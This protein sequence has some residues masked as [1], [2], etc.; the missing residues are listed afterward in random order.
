MDWS[1]GM[2]FT[3]DLPGAILLLLWTA[4]RE[5]SDALEGWRR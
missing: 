3:T 5:D 2:T 1:S 4:L